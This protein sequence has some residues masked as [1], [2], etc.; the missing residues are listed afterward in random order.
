MTKQ[1]TVITRC[2]T[3]S[4]LE[5]TLFENYDLRHHPTRGQLESLAEAS[6]D[7]HSSYGYTDI[8][9]NIEISEKGR[10]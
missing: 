8:T 3:S 9:V 7:W 5:V 6:K 10:S 4:G 2:K 1:V